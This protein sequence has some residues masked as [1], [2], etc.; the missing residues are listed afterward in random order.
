VRR[1]HRPITKLT[2]QN[3]R[4]Q[5]V[6]TR[7]SGVPIAGGSGEQGIDAVEQ[8]AIDNRGMI[9]LDALLPV[10]CVAGI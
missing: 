6:F 8:S 7:V 4:E 2:V 3:P 5:R 9:R 1:D 10:T